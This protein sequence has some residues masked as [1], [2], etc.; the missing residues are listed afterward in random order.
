[1]KAYDIPPRRFFLFQKFCARAKICA[2]A[3]RAQNFFFELGVEWGIVAK[4]MMSRVQN[5][6]NFENPP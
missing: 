5:C 2:R 3:I 1:M 4:P 6:K